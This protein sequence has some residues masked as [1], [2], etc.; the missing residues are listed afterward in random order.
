MS[1]DV[2]AEKF[3]LIRQKLESGDLD[4]KTTNE[5][6]TI[7]LEKIDEIVAVSDDQMLNKSFYAEDSI[8]RPDDQEV[9]PYLFA[10]KYLLPDV[11]QVRNPLDRALLLPMV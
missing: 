3:D 8:T 11:H 2:L 9:E 5:S 4:L 1:V 10:C 7:D 6:I